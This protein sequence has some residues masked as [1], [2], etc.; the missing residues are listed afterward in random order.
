MVIRRRFDGRAQTVFVTKSLPVRAGPLPGRVGL[1]P[2]ASRN[3]VIP[4]PE[5]LFE[6]VCIGVLLSIKQG[7]KEDNKNKQGGGE[8]SY[9]HF[10]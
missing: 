10:A 1:C 2:L 8:G 4:N 3:M 6:L 9:G 7:K 5:L